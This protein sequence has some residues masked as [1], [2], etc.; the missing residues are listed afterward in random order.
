MSMTNKILTGFIWLCGIVACS[1]A[2]W[3]RGTVVENCSDA[4][5]KKIIFAKDI[6][7]KDGKKVGKLG[8]G[9]FITL[10]IIMV[11]LSLLALINIMLSQTQRGRALR[12]RAIGARNSFM[13]AQAQKYM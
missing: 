10:V 9:M 12:S 2:L 13:K 1:V 5:Q 3:Y 6:Y 11:T 7:D 8:D 4:C